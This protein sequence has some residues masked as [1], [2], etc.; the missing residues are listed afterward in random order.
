MLGRKEGHCIVLAFPAV[1]VDS[2][3]LKK[4][5]GQQGQKHRVEEYSLCASTVLSFR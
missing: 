3:S 2:E 4:M 1:D 5:Q